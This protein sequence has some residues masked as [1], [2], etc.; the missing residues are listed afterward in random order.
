M[1][2]STRRK[3]FLETPIHGLLNLHEIHDNHSD[4]SST[5]FS[6]MVLMPR[7]CRRS[8]KGPSMDASCGPRAREKKKESMSPKSPSVSP[9]HSEEDV[10]HNARGGL[11][12][13]VP[14]PCGGAPVLTAVFY[15]VKSDELQRY[16][17]ICFVL[18]LCY[19]LP[20][21]ANTGLAL[22]QAA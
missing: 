5:A 16:R 6:M 11:Q 4:D 12:H 22:R 14:I 18:R 20:R 1:H 8:W 17:Y 9:Q 21:T 10:D 2:A 19:Q 15:D 13:L 7:R 3:E